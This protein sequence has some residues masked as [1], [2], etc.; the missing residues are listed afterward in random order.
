M[1]SLIPLILDSGI[2]TDPDDTVALLIALADDQFELKLFLS[3]NEVDSKRIYLA[4]KIVQQLAP[5][6]PCKFISGIDLHNKDHWYGGFFEPPS[7]R[8][9][10]PYDSAYLKTTIT[11]LI[12]S[13]HPHRVRYI[14]IGG[15]S[16]LAS[17]LSEMEHEYVSQLDIFI[18]GGSLDPTRT[19]AEFNVRLDISGTRKVISIL[20][21]YQMP[22]YLVPSN[23]TVCPELCISNDSPDF[24]SLRESHP[25]FFD[26]LSHHLDEFQKWSGHNRFIST[27][28]SLFAFPKLIRVGQVFLLIL[29]RRAFFYSNRMGNSLVCSLN[30]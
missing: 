16:N 7:S 9:F 14:A 4:M 24:L 11:E 8:K 10:I 17:I 15:F 30:R 25:I 28:H 6:N 13:S 3:A 22:I 23:I 29:M 1:N 5:G 2:G 18:M 12:I 20:Q 21:Q 27:I 26:F 19:K